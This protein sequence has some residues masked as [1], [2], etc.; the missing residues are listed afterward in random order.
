MATAKKTTE[1][2]PKTTKTTTKAK[3]EAK[4]ETKPAAKTTKAAKVKEPAVNVTIQFQG[5]DTS[6]TEII[7]TIKNAYAAS[8]NKAA[9]EKI[10]IYV[11]PENNRAYFVVND[12]PWN[13]PV[14][15]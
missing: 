10:D 7:E 5:K 6:V 14:E 13:E 8:E 12:T 9:L 1:K 15:F 11:Q 2:E 4:A 3:T